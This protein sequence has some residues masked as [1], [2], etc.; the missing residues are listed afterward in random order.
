LGWR[1]GYSDGYS[2]G[3]SADFSADFSAYL[4]AD[5]IADP[6]AQAS[7]SFLFGRRCSAFFWLGCRRWRFGEFAARLVAQVDHRAANFDV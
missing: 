1:A 7:S 5:L 2:D 6:S 4:I 3:F